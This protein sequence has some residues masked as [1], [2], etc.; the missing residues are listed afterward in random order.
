MQ[1]LMETSTTGWVGFLP[2]GVNLADFLGTILYIGVLVGEYPTNF[3][4][5]KLPVA[6]YLAGKYVI[7]T[8]DYG[9]S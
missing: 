4:L 6:K 9:F 3:L 5:Q 7:L 1:V 8:V 2:L